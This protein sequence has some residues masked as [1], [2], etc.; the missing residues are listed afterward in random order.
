MNTKNAVLKN[1]QKLGRDQQRAIKGGGIGGFIIIACRL[2]IE[3]PDGESF[4]EKEVERLHPE[5]EP[6]PQ[7][8]W[9]VY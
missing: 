2:T 1:A 6:I 7:G 4:E 3:S 5:S 8:C 9:A